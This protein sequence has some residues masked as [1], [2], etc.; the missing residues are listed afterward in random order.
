MTD[1]HP[2]EIDAIAQHEKMHP[3]VALEKAHTFLQEKWGPVAI[4]Q[5]VKDELQKAIDAQ[6]Y[7][8]AKRYMK[9]FALSCE[10]HQGGVERRQHRPPQ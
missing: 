2:A 8:D 6:N 4:R 10:L 1:L 5:M 7:E 3:M 9:L